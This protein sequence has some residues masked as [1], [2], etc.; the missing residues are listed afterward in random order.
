[1]NQANPA[2]CL[3]PELSPWCR[4]GGWGED[5]AGARCRLSQSPVPPAG[6][7]PRTGAFELLPAAPVTA[8]CWGGDT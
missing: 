4:P 5:A 6:K 1:M 7:W 3:L 8:L 2:H